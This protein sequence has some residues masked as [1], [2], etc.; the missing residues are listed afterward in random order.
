M[1]PEIKPGPQLDPTSPVISTEIPQK[2]TGVQE[3]PSTPAPPEI[4]PTG[5]D[6]ATPV[7]SATTAEFIKQKVAAPT[8][9]Q[10][11][12]AA[13]AKKKKTIFEGIV[14]YANS[15]K[16]GKSY[17][18]VTANGYPEALPIGS[19]DLN[20]RIRSLLRNN[21]DSIRE[22]EL[23]DLNE[24]L[25]SEAEAVGMRIDLFPRVHPRE[26][27]G[28]EI[29]LCDGAGTTVEI[30]AGK[31]EVLAGTSSTLFLRSATAMAL[32]RPADQGD[33]KQL[34]NYLNL[35]SDLFYLYV[36]WLTFTIAHPKIESTKYVFLVVKGA[37]GSGKSFIGKSSQKLVDPRSIGAQTLPGNERELAI[38]LQSTHLL[39]VDNL[40]EISP[41]LSDVLCIASTG[42][43]V[44]MRKL[45]TDDEQK[46]L[47][48][49]GQ[50]IF[51]GIH[52]FMGQSD[53][54][55]RCLVL[56]LQSLDETER[57][58]E[59]VM[60][61]EFERDTPTILRGL[62]DLVAATLERLPEAKVV[63]PARM[64]DFSK[65]LSA[66]EAALNAPGGSLQHLYV[67]LIRDAK[68]ETLM[69][70]PLAVTILAFV[71]KMQEQSWAGTPSD[72]Y[73]TLETLAGFSGQRSRAWPSSAAVM[74]KRLYGLQA[75]LAAQGVSIELVRG[76]EREIVISKTKA[77]RPSVSARMT[78]APQLLEPIPGS[79]NTTMGAY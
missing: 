68:L 5:A 76:K 59:S 67:D 45:Y 7:V 15:A 25:R 22:R 32:P 12:S 13:A 34:R 56:D 63:A 4:V 24:D 65:W 40:R 49:H 11:R 62:Y 75:P 2:A 71:Q 3:V 42:G 74:S 61:A 47:H 79:S 66:T 18:V 52:P 77:F 64:L 23:K 30:T 35:P 20:A 69:D 14:S 28:V 43:G 53:L 58:F 33:F 27:G 16:H 50:I 78:T 55:D 48:L 19:P 29:D 36:A 57:K 9:A 51:N 44:G 38:M 1:T 6:T 17:A 26:G 21:G 31:V 70:N 72:F 54:A 37:E 39:V 73:E 41:A 60:L 46:S 10:Q 8:A